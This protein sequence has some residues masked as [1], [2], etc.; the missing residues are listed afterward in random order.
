[1]SIFTN[2]RL[3]ALPCELM[4]SCTFAE[5]F[6]TMTRM[7]ANL[8]NDVGSGITADH[9]VTN[10]G[11]AYLI[12]DPLFQG[13][14]FSV[15]VQFSADA[16]VSDYSTRLILSATN[17]LTSPGADGFAIGVNPD[18]IKAN[19]GDGT[20]SLNTPCDVDL[21][22]SD[23]EI[24]T[25]TYVVDLVAGTHILYVDGLTANSQTSDKTGPVGGV[26]DVRIHGVEGHAETIAPVDGHPVLVQDARLVFAAGIEGRG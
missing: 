23:G 18:G 6:V 25:L 13:T 20:G 15:M 2:P 3:A 5:N 4:R 12:S 1:M 10:D 22:Y 8:V 7:S 14:Q 26:D 24:H 11:L 21:D 17:A 16:L 9:G 19:H